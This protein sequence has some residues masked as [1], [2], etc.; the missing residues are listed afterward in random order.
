MDGVSFAV[1]FDDGIGG[2]WE[3]VHHHVQI[4]TIFF[5]GEEGVL[6]LEHV[7]M[8]EQFENLP[9][10]ILVLF[11]LK[12]LL[13]GYNLQSGFV[14]SFVHHSEGSAAHLLVERV[15]LLSGEF[16]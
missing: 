16:L 12:Y 11:I 13:D 3:V 10:S 14:P 4:L 5:L 1:L 2:I 9:L 15:L 8:V 7:V 6:H